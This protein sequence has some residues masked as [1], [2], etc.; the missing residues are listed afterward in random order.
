[1]R[2]RRH[3]LLLLKGMPQPHQPK[4][5]EDEG[6]LDEVDWGSAEFEDATPGKDTGSARS[7]SPDGAGQSSGNMGAH[8]PR[9]PSRNRSPP[10]ESTPV[11]LRPNLGRRDL[12]HPAGARYGDQPDG[13]PAY[14]KYNGTRTH[15]SQPTATWSDV[16]TR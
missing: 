7:E 10:R 2:G 4:D 16:K 11:V 15:G 13:S 14:G 3:A 9:T 6:G 5:N 1:M 12:K 8:R